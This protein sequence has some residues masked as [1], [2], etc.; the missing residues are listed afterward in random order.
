MLMVT[1]CVAPSM[2]T[3][4]QHGLGMAARL[5]PQHRRCHFLLHRLFNRAISAVVMAVAGFVWEQATIE[6]EVARQ[7]TGLLGS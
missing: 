2:E 7:L 5:R 4:Q 3:D 1:L 6:E